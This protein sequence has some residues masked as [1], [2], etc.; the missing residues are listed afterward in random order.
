[1]AR[2]L[3]T[4][5]D[6]LTASFGSGFSRIEVKTG[7]RLFVPFGRIED[8]IVRM[9][10][11]DPPPVPAHFAPSLPGFRGLEHVR[12]PV[13]GTVFDDP[14]F[15]PPAGQRLAPQGLKGVFQGAP[16][17]VRGDAD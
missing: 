8:V 2:S 7:K 14:Q 1:M 4:E 9:S 13:D 15:I 11:S 5:T 17:L 3:P 10:P 16:V 12:R 6:A